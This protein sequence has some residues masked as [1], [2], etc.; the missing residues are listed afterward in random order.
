M[1]EWRRNWKIL[2]YECCKGWEWREQKEKG[3]KEKSVEYWKE[4]VGVLK[5]K[6]AE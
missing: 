5:E 6:S 2:E 4:R 3:L 1:E